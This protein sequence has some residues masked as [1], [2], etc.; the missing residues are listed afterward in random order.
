MTTKKHGIPHIALRVLSL[1]VA[2]S[3][4]VTLVACGGKGDQSKDADTLNVALGGAPSS[5]DPVYATELNTIPVTQ[6]IFEGLMKYVDDGTG[7]GKLTC[8]QAKSYDISEDGLTYTFT[9]RDDIYWSD[10]QAV[11][12]DDFLKAWHRLFDP[13]TDAYYDEFFSFI[14]NAPD[15]L[16]GAAAPS[17][18]GIQA[19]NDKVFE[20]KLSTPCDYFLELCAFPATYPVRA[21]LIEQYGEDWGSQ[22]ETCISNGPFVLSAWEPGVEITLTANPRYYDYEKLGPETL[23]FQTHE[24]SNEAVSLFNSGNIQFNTVT[25]DDLTK[26]DLKNDQF[27]RMDA[28]GVKMIKFNTLAAPFQ[29][30]RVRQAFSLAID[31]NA[32]ADQVVGATPAG[33]YV[34]DGLTDADPEKSFREVGGDYYSIAPEDYAENCRKAQSLLAEAGYPEGKGFPIT[35]YLCLDTPISIQPAEQLVKMWKEVLGV[36]IGIQKVSSDTFYSRKRHGDF[37]LCYQSWYIDYM[38]PAAFL[39][40]FVANGSTMSLTYNSPA[41]DQAMQE[42]Y[43]AENR[44]ERMQALHRAEDILLADCAIAPI[45]FPS[46]IFMEQTDVEGI[47][48]LPAMGYYYLSYAHKTA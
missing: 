5:V 15:V 1:C 45:Y 42:A 40:S 39:D 24:D 41:Y 21:D 18:L 3:L 27:K 29:D 30:A 14:V 32:M 2:A 43:R 38:D 9:L 4:L 7:V 11:T 8:G 44:A 25:P 46:W 22:P 28:I 36:D 16:N 23:V 33:A 34:A 17:T 6:H 47:Y 31:R 20:V 13:A 48:Y 12:A 26:D 37:Q 19:L 35:Q 10:G